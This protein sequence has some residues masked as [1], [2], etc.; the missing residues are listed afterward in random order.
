MLC[1]PDV[2]NCTV[3]T[4]ASCKPLAPA[5][6]PLLCLPGG[7]AIG[8]KA[9]K[10]M[11]VAVVA[12]RPGDGRL[13]PKAFVR[14]RFFDCYVPWAMATILVRGGQCQQLGVLGRIAERRDVARRCAG[15]VHKSSERVCGDSCFA[16]CAQFQRGRRCCLA[17]LGTFSINPLAKKGGYRDTP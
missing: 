5:N 8:G 12:D 3:A 16:D 1:H 6:I 9:E 7:T 17:D 13:G 11:V 4:Y 2:G 10:R 14:R 15:N